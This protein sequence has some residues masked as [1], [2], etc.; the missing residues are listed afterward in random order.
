MPA[1]P[2]GYTADLVGRAIWD[3]CYADGMQ[4]L[5]VIDALLREFGAENDSLVHRLAKTLSLGHSAL[6]VAPDKLSLVPRADPIA[7]EAFAHAVT[8]HD[9][10]SKELKE[11]WRWVYEL[12]THPSNAWH[13]SIKAVE[14]ILK[15]I[16]CPN[17]TKATLGNIVGELRSSSQLWRLALPGPN[18]D[19]NADRLVAMLE[20]IWPNPDRH[21]GGTPT[22]ITFEQAQAVVHLAVTVVQWG[23]AGVLIKKEPQGAR[24][25]RWDPLRPTRR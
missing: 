3:Y 24:R 7:A 12:E 15:P 11:A 6:A 19:F 20:L 23:R 2:H 25:R 8:P 16:V 1:P 5:T 14:H 18:A 9:A 10:A 13:H 4:C 22:V 17:N 21:G